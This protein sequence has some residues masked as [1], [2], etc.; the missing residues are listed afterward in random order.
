MRTVRLIGALGA[1]AVA[2][3]MLGGAAAAA[4][5]KTLFEQNI[6]KWRALDVVRAREFKFLMKPELVDPANRMAGFKAIWEK[7]KAAAAKNGYECQDIADAKLSTGTKDFH[8]TPDFALYKRGFVLRITT[9]NDKDGK[10]QSPFEV[11][12]KD[13]Q[14]D[15]LYWLRVSPLEEAPGLKATKKDIS[16]NVSREPDGTLR[17]YMEKSVALRLTPE[18]LPAKTLGDFGKYYPHLLKIGLPADTPL[19]RYRAND[20]N[21]KIGKISLPDGVECEVTLESWSREPDGKPL[22]NE[23]S[24]GFDGVDYYGKPK[25]HAEA[26]RF[27]TQV[28][29]RDCK[30]LFL[31]NGAQWRGSKVRVLLNMPLP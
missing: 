3:L 14:Q 4:E 22:V 11:T 8:D 13:I 19:T 30:E 15:N 28:L 12:A 29:D 9:K 25:A 6:V 26:E 2:V 5:Q 21:V 1:V 16:E 17:G 18:E 10:P 7:V 24:F 20:Y 31:P 23:F 27:L